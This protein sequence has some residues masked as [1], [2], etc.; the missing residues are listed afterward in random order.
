MIDTPCGCGCNLPRL[1]KIEGRIESNIAI[2]DESISIHQLDEIVYANPRV[3]SFNA[4]LVQ[5]RERNTLH[6]EIEAE[7]AIDKDSLIAELPKKLKLEIRY[8][9]ADPFSRREKRRIHIEKMD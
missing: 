9:N 8:C 3:R 7:S 1:G 2:G 6:L 4:T 5:E